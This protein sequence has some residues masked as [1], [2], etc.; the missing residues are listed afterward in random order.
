[1]ERIF[2]GLLNQNGEPIYKNPNPIG[3]VGSGRPTPKN[4]NESNTK[5]K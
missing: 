2:T 3:F 4:K 1:M 5:T